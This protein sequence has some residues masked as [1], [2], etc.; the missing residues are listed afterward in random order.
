M[1]TKVGGRRREI[2]AWLRDQVVGGR[3][4]DSL[5]SEAELAE[6]F[7]VS[8][9]T[10]RQAVQ[11]LAA[12]GLVYRQRGSGTF[13]A[14]QPLHRHSGQLMS[15]TDDMRRR[16]MVASSKLLSAELRP[17]TREET[18]ALSWLLGNESS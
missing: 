18:S 9:M 16:G 8:R 14:S 5:P 3:E 7:S 13:I 6:K 15:F 4:G 1:S 2:E 12:E 11:S 17:P 10:A